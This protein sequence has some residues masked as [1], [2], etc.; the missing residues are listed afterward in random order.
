MP[1]MVSLTANRYLP[2]GTGSP[3]AMAVA[4]AAPLSTRLS[5]ATGASRAP[6]SIDLVVRRIRTT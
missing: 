2:S 6:T 3:L 1:V 5:A 4:G